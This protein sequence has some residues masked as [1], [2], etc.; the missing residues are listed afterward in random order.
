MLSWCLVL[1]VQWHVSFIRRLCDSMP[2]Q[3][4]P[5]LL[6]S[7]RSLEYWIMPLKMVAVIL[8]GNQ[9]TSKDNRTWHGCCP[10][11]CK[12]DDTSAK[13][14]AH[15]PSLPPSLPTTFVHNG[16]TCLSLLTIT[17]VKLEHAELTKKPCFC[18]KRNKA[19]G[20]KRGREGTE[21]KKKKKRI[22][23]S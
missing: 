8:M 20:E 7:L 10:L 12:N 13:L 15:P 11:P 5:L 16:K 9:R 23:K 6:L 1:A 2:S 4:C 21:D 22:S 3:T 18:Y 14:V 19:S 17:G